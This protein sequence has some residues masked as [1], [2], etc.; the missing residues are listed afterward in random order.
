MEKIDLA[1]VGG[2]AAGLSAALYAAR[3]NL[4]VV[5]F[6]GQS[7]G[8]QITLTNDVENYPGIGVQNPISGPEIANLFLEHA[9]KFGSKTEYSFVQ[10]ISGE[11]GSFKIETMNGNW[12]SK[13]II[14]APGSKAKEIG[15]PGEMELMGLGVSTC[16]TCDGAFFRDREVVVVGGGNSAIEEGIFL[17]RFAS[18]VTIVHRR[19]E[20]RA[21]PVI[22]ERAKKNKKIEWKLDC[23]IEKINGNGKVESVNIKD[24]NSGKENLFK[25]D[26]V[27]IFIGHNPNTGFLKKFIK[28]DAQGY[29]DVDHEQKTNV[30]GIWSAGDCSDHQYKQLITS[31]GDGVKAALNCIHWLEKNN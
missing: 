17:T 30:E 16:A 13:T 27:F 11:A 22:L 9:E 14:L 26:G 21:T 19:K 5:L 2:G 20:F 3:S 12:E 28:T 7:P 31:A 8:G 10:K 24:T 25:T 1:I 18:K 23:T 29:I 15:I 4:N 6:E